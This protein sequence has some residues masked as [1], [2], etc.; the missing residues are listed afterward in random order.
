MVSTLLQ[1]F[2]YL[3]KN[4][5]KFQTTFDIIFTR[6]LLQE[7][8]IVQQL[9]VKVKCLKENVFAYILYKEQNFINSF[10]SS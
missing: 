10:H 2:I 5:L 6:L 8:I 4:Y 7:Q 9:K 3:K 1:T